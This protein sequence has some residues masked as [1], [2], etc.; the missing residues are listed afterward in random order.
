MMVLKIK[1]ELKIPPLEN[2]ATLT[3]A[4][5]MNLGGLSAFSWG[6]DGEVSL[7]GDGNQYAVGRD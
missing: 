4:S 3:G 6:G 1:D 5:L 7:D 2:C